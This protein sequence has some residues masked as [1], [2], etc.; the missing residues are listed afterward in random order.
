MTKNRGVIQPKVKLTDYI[1]GQETGITF[2]IVN[3]LGDWSNYLPSKEGQYITFD[4]MACVSFSALNSLEIQLNY[5]MAMNKIPKD[6]LDKL[7]EWGY[8]DNGK[9]NFSDRF[10]ARM[11]GTTPGGNSLNNVWDSIRRDGLVPESMWSKEGCNNWVQ[12]YNEI[13]QQVKDFGKHIL[14]IFDFKYE[15]V[16]MGN[17]GLADLVYLQQQLTQAPLQ[18]AAPVCTRDSQGIF[19]PCGS[20]QTAH[21][22]VLYGISDNLKNF[23]HYYPYLNEWRKD[24]TMP[25]IMKGIP[26]LKVSETT[27]PVFSHEFKVY[28]GYGQRNEEVLWLQ[29]A[30]N[31]LGYKIPLTGY[32]GN[33]TKASVKDFQTKYKLA[34][35]ITIQYINGRWVGPATRNK[36]NELLKK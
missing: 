3:E 30:L 16:V 27:N 24:Y 2:N 23:D 21:A 7:I 28:I 34:N 5:L 35:W 13:P 25:W 29:K 4:T 8:I 36:L 32:Y 10:T 14:E 31:L 1:A 6:K 20:C 18:I 15:W 9:F 26:I 12:Y 22:T 19:V 33:I 11:S 17:C